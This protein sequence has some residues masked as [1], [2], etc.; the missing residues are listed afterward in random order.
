MFSF[1]TPV[2]SSCNKSPINRYLISIDC[3]HLPST[4]WRSETVMLS[5]SSHTTARVKVSMFVKSEIRLNHSLT[6]SV[7]VLKFLHRM[8]YLYSLYFT[9]YDYSKITRYSW[10]PHHYI[11]TEGQCLYSWCYLCSFSFYVFT[12]DSIY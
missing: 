4:F 10:L 5:I 8:C 6:S 7:A 3:S 12:Y 1:F 2:S 11:A 9:S